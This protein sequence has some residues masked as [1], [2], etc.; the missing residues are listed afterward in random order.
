M[1]GNVKCEAG[2]FFP[3]WLCV[4]DYKGLLPCPPLGLGRRNLYKR[5][6]DEDELTS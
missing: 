4:V 1:R 2:C 3:M 6:S 5:I